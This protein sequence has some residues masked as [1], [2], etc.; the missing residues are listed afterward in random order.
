MSDLTQQLH[1]REDKGRAEREGLLDRLHSLTTEGTHA[2]LQNQ[3]L[4]VNDDNGLTLEISGP[5]SRRQIHFSLEVGLEIAL[6]G[7]FSL[8]FKGECKHFRK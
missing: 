6:N 7:Y 8:G 3:S 5:V 1:G 2:S 4:K